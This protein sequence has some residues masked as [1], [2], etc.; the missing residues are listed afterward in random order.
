ML[1]KLE[2]N[3]L[4]GGHSGQEINKERGNAI[5]LMGR[6]LGVLQGKASVFLR[7]LWGGT[8]DNAIPSSCSASLVVT[9]GEGFH[10]QGKDFEEEIRTFLEN[11]SEEYRKN[12]REKKSR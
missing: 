4:Q 7:E 5:C 1:C 3:G 12:F 6:L 10:S 2:I 11:K 8:A 9:S